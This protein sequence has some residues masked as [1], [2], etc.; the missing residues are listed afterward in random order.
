MD[1]AGELPTFL[2]GKRRRVA[3]EALRQSIEERSTA[4]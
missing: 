4:R 1:K 2:I 3:A